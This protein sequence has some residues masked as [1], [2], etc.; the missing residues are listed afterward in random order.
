[1]GYARII[2]ELLY[3]GTGMAVLVTCVSQVRAVE[4]IYCYGCVLSVF[5]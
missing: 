4:E 5:D 1:M 3:P 2:M